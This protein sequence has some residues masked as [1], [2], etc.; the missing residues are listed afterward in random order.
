[1]ETPAATFKKDSFRTSQEEWNEY[2][3]DSGITVR[4]KT[5]VTDIQRQLDSVGHQAI[6]SGGQPVVRVAHQTIV[7]AHFTEDISDA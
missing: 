4:V 3:L 5:V 6:S 2:L 7:S 1:M